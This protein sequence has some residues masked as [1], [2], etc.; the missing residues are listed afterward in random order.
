M[1][2]VHK[3]GD[4]KHELENATNGVRM[5]CLHFRKQND[6]SNM[7]EYIIKN[8]KYHVVKERSS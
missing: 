4:T 2:T 7:Q 1:Y 6:N 3:L 5:R 8:T